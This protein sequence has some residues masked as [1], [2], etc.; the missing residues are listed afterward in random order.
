M[1]SYETV[2]DEKVGGFR[3]KLMLNSEGS[4]LA[5]IK[6]LSSEEEL[7]ITGTYDTFV[8]KWLGFLG[9]IGVYS[10]NPASN[11]AANNWL[12]LLEEENPNA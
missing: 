5:V 7:T 8:K 11:A 3:V 2:L 1:R 9:A 10:P 12:K 4:A 6:G